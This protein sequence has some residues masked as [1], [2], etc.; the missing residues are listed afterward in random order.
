MKTKNK[1]DFEGL[2]QTEHSL[3]EGGSNRENLAYIEECLQRQFSPSQTLRLMC[4]L[5]LTQE[6]LSSRDYKSLKTQFLQ[7]SQ[8]VI[9]SMTGNDWYYISVVFDILLLNHCWSYG[10]WLM[11][12]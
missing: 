7:V 6:G 10:E 3:L 11:Q 1:S 2:I 9:S 8:C 12:R 5:S 4:L